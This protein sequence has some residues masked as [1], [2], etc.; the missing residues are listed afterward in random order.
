[1]RDSV[2]VGVPFRDQRCISMG[3]F[4]LHIIRIWFG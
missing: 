1:M 3:T 2:A 4:D